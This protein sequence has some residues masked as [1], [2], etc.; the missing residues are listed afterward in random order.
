MAS[1]AGEK[2]AGVGANSASPRRTIHHQ[3][4]GA[5][6]MEASHGDSPRRRR[7]PPPT[8]RSA[9]RPREG[10]APAEPGMNRSA[11]R[12]LVGRVRRTRRFM[13]APSARS[14]YLARAR[15]RSAGGAKVRLS[16]AESCSTPVS[17][18]TAARQEPRPTLPYPTLPCPARRNHNRCR[19]FCVTRRTCTR[20]PRYY[21]P[22]K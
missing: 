7:A 18:F 12:T 10:E 4:L 6:S 8:R 3:F 5:R 14:P 11:R 16:R 22:G 1:A 19:W 17:T 13:A 21:I 2:S 15:R 9:S 20:I